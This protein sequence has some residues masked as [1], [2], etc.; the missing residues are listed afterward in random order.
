M[1]VLVMG[2]QELSDAENTWKDSA[3]WQLHVIN[4]DDRGFGFVFLR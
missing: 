4:G 3:M 2:S 1:S